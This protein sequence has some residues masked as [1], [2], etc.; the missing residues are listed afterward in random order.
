MPNPVLHKLLILSEDANQYARLIEDRRLP[1]LSLIL[2]MGA[3]VP[4]D[5]LDTC[6]IILGEPHRIAPVISRAI[7][8]KWV[9]STYAGVDPLVGLIPFW[10]WC[11]RPPAQPRGSQDR[12]A[13]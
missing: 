8:L 7:R 9:Q 12:T 1:D 4:R 10:Q 13:L 3:E 5:A 2:H 6:D 11:L